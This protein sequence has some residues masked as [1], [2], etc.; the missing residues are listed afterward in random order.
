[1][2]IIKLFPGVFSPT[3]ILDN[4]KAMNPKSLLVVWVDQAGETHIETDSEVTMKDVCYFNCALDTWTHFT[5]TGD[6]S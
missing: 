4:V 3:D 6:N 1:M 2:S 5:L